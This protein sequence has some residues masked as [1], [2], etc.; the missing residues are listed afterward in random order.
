MYFNG[1]DFPNEIVEAIKKGKFV[2]FAGAGASVDKPTSLPDFETL[3]NMIAEDTGETKKKNDLCEVFL[4]A[5]EAK[6]IDVRGA[7]AG[8]L[9]DSC[10]E[11]NK[12]HETIVDLFNCRDDIKIVTTNYDQ[13]FEHV[14]QSRNE[15]IDVYNAPTLPLGNDIS[16][17]VHIH[18]NVNNPKYMVLTDE[19]F[20]K[21]YLTE[22]Y[23]SRFL[24][25]LFESY[26]ILFIGYSYNDTI[27]RYLT[28]AMSRNDGCRRYILT[29]D[30]KTD[31]SLLGINPIVFP[32]RSY[33][34]M[35]DGLR[36]LGVGSKKGLLEW[37]SQFELFK[38]SP[39]RDMTGDKE[40]EYCLENEERSLILAKTICGKEWMD[41]LDKK[42][43]FADCFSAD[44]KG[45]SNL[46][47]GDWLCK[48][49][50][51]KDDKS[52]LELIFHHKN[53]IS[54]KLANGIASHLITINGEIDEAFLADYILLIEKYIENDWTI[55]KLI[56]ITSSKKQWKTSFLLLQK[57]FS[58]NM[59]LIQKGWI[60]PEGVEFKHTFLGSYFLIDMAWNR[61]IEN[62]V[63][64][65]PR[66]II[67]FVEAKIQELHQKY[68]IV[69]QG[70]ND[71]VAFEIAILD[72]ENKK[73]SYREN[74]LEILA[75]MYVESV[76]RLHKDEN[77]FLRQVLLNDLNSDSALMRKIALRAF[78]ETSAFSPS[79]KV[80]F[81]V[82]NEYLDNTECKEQVFL[83]VA[84]CFPQLSD[85]EKKNLI[86]AIKELD[87]GD[88]SSV[89]YRVY[90]WIVWLN[91]ADL[92]DQYTHK[93]KE[94]LQNEYGYK[95]SKHPELILSPTEVEWSHNQSPVSEEKFISLEIDKVINWLVSFNENPF[96][97]PSREGLL[98]TFS[99]CI[100][101]NV[102]W[103]KKVFEHLVK[104]E[105]WNEDIWQ[106]GIYASMNSDCSLDDALWALRL[107]NN[108][109]SSIGNV[110]L[111]AEYLW[112]MVERSD[113][114]EFVLKY[115]SEFYE[116]T[117]NLWTERNKKEIDDLKGGRIIEATLYTA[118][119]YIL[120]SWIYMVSFHEERII[121]AQYQD[122]FNDALS[123]KTTEKNVARCILVGHFN[124]F[125]YRDKNWSLDKLA[126]LL[127]SNNKDCFTS[128]WGGIVYFS[129]RINSDTVD[130]IEPIYF[131]ALKHID[132]LDD[133]ALRAF[134]ELL[135]TLMIYVVD[136]P[137]LKYI[138]EYYK[139][140]S[141]RKRTILI[142]TINSRLRD[143]DA[144][145]KLEWWNSWLKRFIV[146]RKNNK[147]CILEEEENQE[148]LDLVTVFPEQFED[149]VE[150]VCKGKM[151]KK[152]DSSF[153]LQL[154]E[155]NLS[156]EKPH[157]MAKLLIRIL[158]SA[159]EISFSDTFIVKIVEELGP[160]DTKEKKE[161]QEVLLK[162]NI[163]VEL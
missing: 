79:E 74:Q 45:D 150:V 51:G 29:D 34:V 73:D 48:N 31:W 65:Y 109:I 163:G 86:Q 44:C 107:F 78:R 95:E 17:I 145:K 5:L 66:E 18:G 9:S 30:E 83:L 123:L 91:R 42:N 146:N 130:I 4:G 134:T 135:L 156:S 87:S 52:F 61:M 8:I 72:I 37:K 122:C 40:I 55:V 155:M 63:E 81:I 152:I 121:P 70:I 96:E 97:G 64:F 2:V 75:N 151:P 60:K 88:K 16:G 84:K 161:L 148:I 85:S 162:R 100:T 62:A 143:M 7:A 21:A 69:G 158:E 28:R 102:A 53:K 120:F 128:S 147:P 49:F 144:S 93:L 58:L 112:K 43:I 113:A 99:A 11:H 19:D 159:E 139:C 116:I 76:L 39:P 111:I 12:L 133:E 13:M 131:K 3:T 94:Q 132:W 138:P 101:K 106:R 56:E 32:K 24:V 80:T 125:C 118:L 89:S 25:R 46:I 127:I 90:N 20:G 126:P 26:T 10:K 54:P 153:W 82:N 23:A 57:L 103:G 77:A 154:Q 59:V 36:K 157:Y 71:G 110:T 6:G 108:N 38:Y 22:G 104:K 1:I 117:Q 140:I 68:E 92:S 114:R 141:T 136:K 129:S 105:I 137:T 160:L 47:W 41:Y 149:V 124:F 50:V 33:A 119:G 115:E 27:L 35:R 98:N 67:S 14:I 142:N 15:V